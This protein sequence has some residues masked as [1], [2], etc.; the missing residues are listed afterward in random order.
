MA[1]FK[2]SKQ[3]QSSVSAS[4]LSKMGVCERLV[5]FEHRHG[6][7]WPRERQQVVQRGLLAHRRFHQD[8]FLDQERLGCRHAIKLTAQMAVLGTAQFVATLFVRWAKR[9][10]RVLERR[11]GP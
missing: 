7:Q 3:N 4:E 9:W 5:V 11:D 1:K 10:F 2:K 8:R 6:K